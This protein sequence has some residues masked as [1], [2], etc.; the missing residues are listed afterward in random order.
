MP[1][2]TYRLD[3]VGTFVSQDGSTAEPIGWLERW[4][5]TQAQYN[6]IKSGQM[7]EEPD[8]GVEYPVI[9]I[10]NPPPPGG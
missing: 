2:F 6:A 7:P 5:I 10:D 1:Y 3:A 4:E 8:T 9:P